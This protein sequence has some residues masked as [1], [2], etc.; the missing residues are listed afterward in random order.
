MP[1]DSP[2]DPAGSRA[3]DVAPPS[4]PGSVVVVGGGLAAGRT[5]AALRTH[6][7]EGTITVVAAEHHAPYDR[8]PLSKELLSRPEPA[9]LL[10]E[11]GGDLAEAH[12][13]DVHLG[14]PATGLTLTDDA[15]TIRTAAGDVTADAAVLA[16]GAHAVLPASLR[17]AL[18][19]HTADDAAVLRERLRPGARLVVVGAGWIGAE[20]AGVASA[21]DVEVTVVEAGAAPLSG[22]VGAQVGHLLRP[23]YAAA[24]VALRTGTGVRAVRP[25]PTGAVVELD[26]GGTLGAD[27]VLAAVGARPTTSWIGDTLPRT[28]SDALAVDGWYRVLGPDGAQP[29]VLAVGDVATRR[30]VRHGWVPGGHWDAALRGPDTAAQGLV[31][32]FAGEPADPAPYV[33]S[34]QLGHELGMY[35]QPGPTDEVVLRGDPRGAFTALWCAPGTDRLTAVLAVDRPADVAAA[36]RLLAARELPVVDRAAAADPRVRLRDAVGPASS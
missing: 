36:R 22:A 4:A 13:A 14:R 9:W 18:T 25:G 5:V 32:G 20:V 21:A 17:G 29:R 33:F 16:T 3:S 12:G 34:T 19:L 10:D 28:A 31:T 26:D 30:S 1:D 27:V 8:P 23:W 2:V 7:F 24:G 35:G 11:L 6:G 15:V